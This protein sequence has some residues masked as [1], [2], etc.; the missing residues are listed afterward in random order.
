MEEIQLIG[1][2]TAQRVRSEEIF[3]FECAKAWISRQHPILFL[4]RHLGFYKGKQYLPDEKNNYGIFLD[5]SPDR[6]GRL[7]MRRRE[8]WQAKEEGKNECTLFE[9]MKKYRRIHFASAMTLLGLQ[10]GADHAE[11][12]GCLDLVGFIMQFKKFQTGRLNTGFNIN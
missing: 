7:L 1:V 10:D 3:S 12:I 6:W 5:S 8:A 2:L 4:D 9:E 11:G